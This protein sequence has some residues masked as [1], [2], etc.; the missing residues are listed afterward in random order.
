MGSGNDYFLKQYQT[1]YNTTKHCIFGLW[2][3]GYDYDDYTVKHFDVVNT[4]TPPTPTRTRIYTWISA[5]I[6]VC[7]SATSS[8]LPQYTHIRTHIHIHTHAHTHTRTTTHI[9]TCVIN[10]S[11]INHDCCD[12]KT[13]CLKKMKSVNDKINNTYWY[14]FPYQL[15]VKS[16]FNWKKIENRK[17]KIWSD[18][19][20]FMHTF[21]YNISGG[22]NMKNENIF[23]RVWEICLILLSQI[24]NFFSHVIRFWMWFFT[25]CEK[26]FRFMR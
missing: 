11:I 2:C 26:K 13:L 9:H 16:I 12:V 19:F 4:E 15:L 1:V 20:F 18:V 25:P 23:F 6:V 21:K 24:Y 8:T 7:E 14:L 10:G 3:G 22:G 5:Q 17:K